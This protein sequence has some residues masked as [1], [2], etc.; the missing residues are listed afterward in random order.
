[1][2]AKTRQPGNQHPVQRW[3]V[4]DKGHRNDEWIMAQ[5]R[6]QLN[7]SAPGPVNDH[8]GPRPASIE[9]LQQDPPQQQTRSHHPQKQENAETEKHLPRHAALG[10]PA[11]RCT[12]QRNQRGIADRAGKPRRFKTVQT[13]IRHP[14]DRGG[15]AAESHQCHG[16]RPIGP[17]I[18]GDGQRSGAR[19]NRQIQ[20]N[21][22]DQ[23][24]RKNENPTFLRRCQRAHNAVNTV[25][26]SVHVFDFHRSRHSFLS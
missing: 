11:H 12:H 1:M 24:I 5:R 7:A 8:R 21:G 20:R 2:G 17:D 4:I 6:G 25:V 15:H 14:K 18:R 19:E 16:K 26:V 13:Q 22:D 10:E 9:D 3:V 23:D